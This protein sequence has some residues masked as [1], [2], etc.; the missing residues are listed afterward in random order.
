MKTINLL[1]PLAVLALALTACHNEDELGGKGLAGQAVQITV[2]I[3]GASSENREYKYQETRLLRGNLSATKPVTFSA[4]YPRITETALTAAS[5]ETTY[6]IVKMSA[7][8][9]A[10]DK[11]P[12][13]VLFVSP[14]TDRYRHFDDDVDDAQNH[15]AGYNAALVVGVLMEN[16]TY[17]DLEPY[18][19]PLYPT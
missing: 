19:P 6:G 16:M 13:P 9:A 1:L 14:I 17:S 11:Q 18:P 10:A 2:I 7:T 12:C 5:I 3:D 4:H 15:I 8:E